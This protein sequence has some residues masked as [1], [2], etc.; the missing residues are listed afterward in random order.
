M[1]E[2][3]QLRL[4]IHLRP[5]AASI[6]QITALE[7]EEPPRSLTDHTVIIAVID[8]TPSELAEHLK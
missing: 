4:T 1:A 6:E 3:C 2:P 5:H 8:Y 7:F